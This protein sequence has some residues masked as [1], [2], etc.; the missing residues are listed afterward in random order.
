MKT[1]AREARHE[2]SQ[3]SKLQAMFGNDKTQNITNETPKSPGKD[4]YS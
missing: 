4:S 1:A 3:Y 2:A